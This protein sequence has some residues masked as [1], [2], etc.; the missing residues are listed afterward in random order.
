MIES[1]RPSLEGVPAC[2]GFPASLIR[3]P[4]FLFASVLSILLIILSDVYYLLALSEYWYSVL[5]RDPAKTQIT[6]PRVGALDP[7]A[8]PRIEMKIKEFQ[9]CFQG[10]RRHEN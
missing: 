1:T 4:R 5:V 10:F 9:P 3:C 2:E 7:G 6:T 8:P